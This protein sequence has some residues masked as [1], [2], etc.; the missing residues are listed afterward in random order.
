MSLS[1]DY[2]KNGFGLV[3]AEDDKD[4]AYFLESTKK[5]FGPDAGEP[6]PYTLPGRM[7]SGGAVGDA[8]YFDE[9]A[10]TMFI[11]VDRKPGEYIENHN[12]FV[13][14]A[15]RQPDPFAAQYT[16]ESVVEEFRKK[17]GRYLPDGFDYMA[18]IGFFTCTVYCR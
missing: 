4:T 5:T 12:L 9:S 17:I 3:I 13:F 6:W 8:A 7:E 14:S 10:D 1:G 18:H 11:P 16:K 2:T 15:D